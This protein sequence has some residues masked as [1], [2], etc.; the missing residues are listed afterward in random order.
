MIQKLSTIKVICMHHTSLISGISNVSRILHW[1][2][3]AQ[4]TG[5][6]GL[7]VAGYYGCGAILGE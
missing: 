5:I 3:V 1:R 2:G 4:E 7:L 6:Q